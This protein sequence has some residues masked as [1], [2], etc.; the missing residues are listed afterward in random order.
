MD[1]ISTSVLVFHLTPGQSQWSWISLPPNRKDARLGCGVK[2]GAQAF[3]VLFISLDR[4]TIRRIAPQPWI[5]SD[6]TS[7]AEQR[8]PSIG[9]I[10]FAREFTW[11]LDY[12][13][14]QSSFEDKDAGSNMNVDCGSLV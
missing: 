3:G 6:P 13:N 11:N 9:L 14:S 5:I 2:C 4:G 12:E 1:F 7:Q 8:A 10:V